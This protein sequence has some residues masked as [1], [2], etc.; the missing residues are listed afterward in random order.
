[1]R[2]WGG[3]PSAPS[4][5]VCASKESESGPSSEESSADADLETELDA[6]SEDSSSLESCR[7]TLAAIPD[8]DREAGLE[9][10]S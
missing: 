7:L 4:L 10:T 1:M 5:V 9:A 6:D 8:S 2:A 3:S